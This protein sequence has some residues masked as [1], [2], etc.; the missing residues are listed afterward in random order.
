M[1]GKKGIFVICP[2]PQD[3]A[4]GQ[5]LKYEQYFEHW[6][7]NGYDI[8]VSSFMDMPM[9]GIV[10]KPGNYPAKILGTL[11]GHL[12]RIRDIFRVAFYDVVYI[13]MWVTPLGTSFFERSV[14]ALSKRMIYDIEDNLLLE[15]SNEVNPF[16]KILKGTRKTKFLIETADHVITSSPVLND[17]CLEINR[18]KSC[19]FVSSSLDTDRFVP[20]GRYSN[21][22][23]VTIGWTGT[24]SSK[25]YL[26][27][28]RNVFL[29]LRKRCDFR[30]RIIGNFQYELAGIDLEVIQWTR[31]REIED[32]QC[33]DIGVY[34]LSQ[35]DW[36]LGKSGLKALQY[37]ALGL[38]TVATNVGTTPKII[39]HGKN[40]WLVRSD[41]EWVDG[42]EA[43]V[44]DS[45]LRRAIGTA[46]R[47]TVLQ[48]YS[49]NV[50]RSTYLSILNR[51]ID[52]R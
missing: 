9:W 37:M 35:D 5:R 10:Y 45:A 51:Q 30:L 29:E 26:D 19:T 16:I 8:T 12:R 14:R 48:S 15:K 47:A 38:P 18:K 43:L 7:E 6:R 21:E 46:A 49:T 13:H 2:F 23:K 33:L 41:E 20:L 40:G 50:I 25:V 34:P 39:R 1:S 32:L 11:R 31:E 27:L 3:V 28:L 42:L 44:K 22:R 24:F 36:V 52:G 4:A 17:H